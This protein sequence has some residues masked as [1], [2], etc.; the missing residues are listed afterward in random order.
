MDEDGD[1]TGLYEGQ[2]WAYE[3]MFSASG[4]LIVL[5]ENDPLDD[6]AEYSVIQ[7]DA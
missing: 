4:V 7:V 3:V 5:D 6:P 2:G 1:G